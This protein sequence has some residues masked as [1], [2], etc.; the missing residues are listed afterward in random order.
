MAYSRLLSLTLFASIAVAGLAGNTHAGGYTGMYVFG[1]S[2]EDCGYSS[3]ERG[4]PYLGSRASNGRVYVEIAA[5]SLGLVPLLPS[6]RGGTDYAQHN[7]MTDSTLYLQ[8]GI[9]SVGRQVNDYISGLGEQGLADSTALYVLNC[10]QAE[11]TLLT[12]ITLTTEENLNRAL[13]S[14]TRMI[15]YIAALGGRGARY[16]AVREM[17]D[18]LPFKIDWNADAIMLYQESSKSAKAYNDSLAA[19]AKVAGME[20]MIVE[21][22]PWY[23]LGR[24]EGLPFDDRANRSGGAWDPATVCDNYFLLSDIAALGWGCSGAAHRLL[25][26]VFL[27]A[28]N[29]SPYVASPIEDLELVVGAE[30]WSV[31]LAGQAA[32]FVDLDGDAMQL[33]ASCSDTSVARVQISEGTLL[34]VAAASGAASISVTAQDP[35]GKSVSVSFSVTMLAGGCTA[36]LDLDPSFENQGETSLSGVVTDTKPEIQL[37]VSSIRD[38]TE[39]E[40]QIEYDSTQLA[41]DG[42]APGEVSGSASASDSSG[43]ITITARN[44]SPLTADEGLLG[45]ITFTTVSTFSGATVGLDSGWITREGRTEELREA[46]SVRLSASQCDFGGNGRVDFADFLVFARGFGSQTG[47]AAF[48]DQLDLDG[49]QKIDFMDFLLFAKDFGLRTQAGG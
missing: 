28:V 1:G 44:D 31:N 9:Q 15:G 18:G 27:E 33:S 36:S 29:R 10:G 20:V 46:T 43:V 25:A 21:N 32:V 4:F 11:S 37:F 12:D 40:M 2:L 45:T 38:A 14:A 26:Q 30:D 8:G 17:F 5:D 23:Y 13:G 48:S 3:T 16:F 19:F 49:N 7:A 34:V 6:S 35:R 42:F 41:F 39:I 47:D 24:K 22:A